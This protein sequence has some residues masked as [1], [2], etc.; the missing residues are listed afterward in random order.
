MNIKGH[1][2]TITHHRH[3]V[4]KNCFKAGIPLNGLL[5]DLSKYTP[6]ELVPGILNYEEGKR[7]PN[8]KEREAKGYSVAWLHHKGRNKHHFEY[9]FDVSPKSHVYEAVPMPLQYLKE[10]FCDRVAASKNYKGEKYKDTDPL[11][12]FLTRKADKIMHPC[13]ACILEKWLRMLAEDGEEKTF[14]YIRS[15]G[16]IECT[17]RGITVK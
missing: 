4:M 14:K 2:K 10:T 8:E 17:C 15:V 7:S 16:K 5:H 12:Y 13:T 11:E 6:E 9:W 3:L 1:L